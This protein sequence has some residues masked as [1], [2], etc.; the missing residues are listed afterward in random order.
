MMNQIILFLKPLFF[1]CYMFSSICS[2]PSSLLPFSIF[3]LHR[4]DARAHHNP[5]QL[6]I[7]DNYLLLW[8]CTMFTLIP[9]HRNYYSP[10][11][12]CF[13]CFSIHET[14]SHHPRCHHPNFLQGFVNMGSIVHKSY[15]Q[16]RFGYG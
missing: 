13:V 9:A 4:F 10:F 6:A 1:S 3:N 8:L 16:Q 7:T 14:R 11:S 15:I 2:I 12:P 5:H